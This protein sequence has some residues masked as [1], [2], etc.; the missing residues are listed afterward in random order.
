MAHAGASTRIIFAFDLGVCRFSLRASE[1][2]AT[3]Q[4]YERA[5]TRRTEL[6]LHFFDKDSFDRSVCSDNFPRRHV[7]NAATKN[8]SKTKCHHD[9]PAP[10]SKIRV[11]KKPFGKVSCDLKK[12]GRRP[13]PDL[14]LPAP[15]D[16]E[17]WP[18]LNT[19]WYARAGGE[20]GKEVVSSALVPTQVLPL[21]H[22]RPPLLPSH[23]QSSSPLRH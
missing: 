3:G 5:R 16:S 2:Q 19:F 17:H 14:L 1:C 6:V 20:W 18:C 15:G 9:R 10:F 7:Q 23:I 4:L 13:A 12:K 22:I 8:E 21:K 11:K